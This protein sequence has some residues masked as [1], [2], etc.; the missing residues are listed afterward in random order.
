MRILD[1]NH[2]LLM[3][4]CSLLFASSAMAFPPAPGFVK[5]TQP[6]GTKV[7]ARIVGDREFHYYVLRDGSYMLADPADGFLKP[8]TA[9]KVEALRMADIARR[10]AEANKLAT[11]SEPGVIKRDF[12]TTGTVKGLIVLAEFQDVKFQPASTREYFET[13]LNKEGYVGEETIGSALDYFKEQSYGLFTPEFDVVGPITLPKTRS[14]YGYDEDLDNLF[15]DA[16]L[17][18]DSDCEVNFADYDIDN[19]HYVDFFFVIFAG[20]GEAQGGPVESVWPAMKDMSYY[21]SDR[22]DGKYIG[23]AACSCELK[24]GEGTDSD[25]ISTICHE[26]S[27]ILGLPDIYDPQGTGGYGMGHFD[28]MC[29]GSYNGDM[30]IPSGFTAMDKYTLGW[31]TPRVLEAPEK[32]VTLHDIVSSKECIF[33]VNPTNNNEY[34]TLENR[35]LQGFDAGLPGHGLVISY[36]NYNRNAWKKNTVNSLLSGYEHV[37]I[38]AADNSRILNSTTTTQNF[39]A[40]D[41]FPGVKDVTSFTDNSVPKAYW[42]ASGSLK[43][44]GMPITN[45][46]ESADGVITFD[47]MSED[48]GVEEIGMAEGEKEYYSL[49]GIKVEPHSLTDGVYIVRDPNGQTRKMMI[50]K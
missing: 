48:S 9:D 31:I 16:A 47:F 38:V 2:K 35:Q 42:Q 26:F 28:M 11:R 43:P 40:G 23:V 3:F 6:D 44:I 17:L 27:H 15:R 46:R 7:E 30:R 22:F 25:G 21:I 33:I 37:S 49:Q 4:A 19:D 45:I 20:H 24:G 18:A 12:P 32:D 10:E 50:R 29:Y 14:E 36:V 41:P 1:I 8:S 39:E 13:K 5:I 34:Y